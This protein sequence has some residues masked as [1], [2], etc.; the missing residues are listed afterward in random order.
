LPARLC[1]GSRSFPRTRAASCSNTSTVPPRG[2]AR[3]VDIWRYCVTP[4]ISAS[5]FCNTSARKRAGH[6]GARPRRPEPRLGR[7]HVRY[8]SIH[9][10]GR[11]EGTSSR[12]IR[13]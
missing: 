3:V 9:A 12:R 1:A 8:T 6:E 7:H 13:T 10:G 4:S 5:S 2:T 11:V